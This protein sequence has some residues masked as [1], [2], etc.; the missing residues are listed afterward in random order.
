MSRSST[1]GMVS[2]IHFTRVPKAQRRAKGAPPAS[3]LALEARA[4]FDAGSL[5]EAR[6]VLSR[7]LAHHTQLT[8][9][10]KRWRYSGVRGDWRRRRSWGTGMDGATELTN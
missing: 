7:A 6:R 4:Q 9:Q 5:P 3:L 1:N 2:G 8:G 10:L